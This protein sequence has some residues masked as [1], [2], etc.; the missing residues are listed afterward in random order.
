VTTG[1]T[2]DLELIIGRFGDLAEKL[3]SAYLADDELEFSELLDD[4]LDESAKAAEFMEIHRN[5]SSEKP[6]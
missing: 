5:A 2:I 3:R 1:Y 4:L 6:C